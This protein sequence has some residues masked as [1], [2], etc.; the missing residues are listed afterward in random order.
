MI[1]K[2]YP[3]VTRRMNFIGNNIVPVIDLHSLSYLDK[4]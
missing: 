4:S 1:G 2:K 3:D